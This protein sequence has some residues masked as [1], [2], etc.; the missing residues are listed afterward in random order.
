VGTAR[1]GSPSCPFGC[2]RHPC[3]DRAVGDN[4]MMSFCIDPGRNVGQSSEAVDGSRTQTRRSQTPSQRFPQQLERLQR[5]AGNT[6]VCQLLATVVAQR[7]RQGRNATRSPRVDRITALCDPHS[8]IWQQLNPNS[9]ATN[10][11]PATTAALDEYIRSG[12]IRPAVAG[13]AL[14]TF[15]YR[16]SPLGRVIN[17]GPVLTR[18]GS[19]LSTDSRGDR[20]LVQ[21]RGELPHVGSFIVVRGL[22]PNGAPYTDDHWFVVARCPRLGIRVLDAFGAGGVFEPGTYIHDNW[23]DRVQWY[24]GEFQVTAQQQDLAS[25]PF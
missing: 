9:Q 22:R 24:R 12:T 19:L 15:S 25:S 10:N 21:A 16:T 1:S 5:S 20:F 11:C 14:T 8:A 17:L 2:P 23:F 4:R 6:A 7:Q 18:A 13:D 3:C